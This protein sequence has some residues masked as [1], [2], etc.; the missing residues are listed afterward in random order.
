MQNIL[1]KLSEWSCDGVAFRAFPEPRPG[2]IPLYRFCNVHDASHA[3]AAG[4]GEATPYRATS[5]DWREEKPTCHAFADPAPGTTPVIRL[6]SPDLP[7]CR[8]AVGEAERDAILA[9]DPSFAP[10]GEPFYVQP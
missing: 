2:T 10:A 3:F 1:A 5:S 9:A 6:R 8:I 4:D 7:G